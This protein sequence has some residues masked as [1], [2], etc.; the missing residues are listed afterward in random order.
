MARY[1]KLVHANLTS[2]RDGRSL[3]QT[4]PWSPGFH[5]AGRSG[6]ACCKSGCPFVSSCVRSS[7]VSR[8]VPL[9]PRFQFA[10][11]TQWWLFSEGT[12]FVRD[13]LMLETHLVFNRQ[14][15]CE[16]MPPSSLCLMCSQT[17]CFYC[18]YL[19]LQHTQ[20]C[21]LG[22]ILGMV[23]IVFTGSWSRPPLH[24]TPRAADAHDARLLVLTCQGLE[25]L[26][27][28]MLARWA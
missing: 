3:F 10:S 8:V 12:S 2:S 22:E 5:R 13:A 25:R 4:M 9:R 28:V 16:S 27:L 15:G 19:G 1:P 26:M 11:A 6:T 23:R 18:I 20:N 17:P 21:T 24:C 7:V 14:K